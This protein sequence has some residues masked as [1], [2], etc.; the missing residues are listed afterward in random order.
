MRAAAQLGQLTLIW[1]WEGSDMVRE[2]VPTEMIAVFV[3]KVRPSDTTS[4]TV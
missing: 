3:A 2:N 1:P 4:V